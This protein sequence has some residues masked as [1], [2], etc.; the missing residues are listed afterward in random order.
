MS[1]ALN[2]FLI[3]LAVNPERMAQFMRDPTAEVERAQ[4]TV[5]EADA[6][7]TRDRIRIRAVMNLARVTAI[8]DVEDIQ[9]GRRKGGTKK[10]SRKPSTKKKGPRKPSKKKK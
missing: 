4:L 3:D 5:E 9:P 10:P 7:L 6:V 8:E 1:D 2:D